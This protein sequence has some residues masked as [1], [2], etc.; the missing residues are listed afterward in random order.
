MLNREREG[1][2]RGIVGLKEKGSDTEPI[3][4]LN[5]EREREGIRRGIVGRKEKRSDI[6]S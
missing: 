3:Q 5:R 1:I 6:R 4:M 2:R